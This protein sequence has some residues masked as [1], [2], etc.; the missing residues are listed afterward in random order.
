MIDSIFTKL[1]TSFILS[2]L[3]TLSFYIFVKQLF[4]KTSIKP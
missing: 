1:G 4:Q 3:M 2:L